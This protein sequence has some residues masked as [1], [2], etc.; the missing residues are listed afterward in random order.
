MNLKVNQTFEISLKENPA[1]GY[2]WQVLYEDL[3]KNGLSN[4]LQYKNSTFKT[5]A[6]IGGDGVRIMQ[7]QV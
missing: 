3:D 2:L 7:F 1:T 4:V 6:I 5:N